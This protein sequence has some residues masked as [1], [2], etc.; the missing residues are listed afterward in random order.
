[1]NIEFLGAFLRGLYAIFSVNKEIK[2]QPK[3][4]KIELKIGPNPADIETIEIYPPSIITS[5]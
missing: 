2:I 3:I 1:M 5:P 4:V